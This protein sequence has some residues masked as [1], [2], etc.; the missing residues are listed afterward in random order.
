MR[1]VG[2]K[3][4]RVKAGACESHE[5]QRGCWAAG[6]FAAGTVGANAGTGSAATLYCNSARVGA[7]WASVPQSAA[8]RRRAWRAASGGGV[9]TRGERVKTQSSGTGK[10]T[11]Q[12]GDGVL[13]RQ[14]A[15]SRQKE[16]VQQIDTGSVSAGGAEINLLQA[17][18]VLPL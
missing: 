2:L 1:V 7:G 10:G 14:R 5:R 4:S 16:G 17:A 8:W 15:Q 9:L 11:V 18:P 6:L 13:T 3:P 12:G